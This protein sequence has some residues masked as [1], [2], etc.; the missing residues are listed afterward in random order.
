MRC[1]VCKDKSEVMN[2]YSQGEITVRRRRC[3][4]P[5]CQKRF[6]TTEHSGPI[7]KK[8][9]TTEDVMASL[10]LKKSRKTAGF[11]PEAVAAALAVDRRRAMI[12]DRERQRD[13]D[14]EW[15]DGFEPAPRRLN[16]GELRRELEGI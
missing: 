4:N 7:M 5:S 3:L 12:R 10:N 15:D 8:E 11:D 13:R 16:R 6:K 1:P 14:T 2:T 9:I